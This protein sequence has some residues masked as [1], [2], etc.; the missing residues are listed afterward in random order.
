MRVS[1]H[2][3]DCEYLHYTDNIIS[4]VGNFINV[5]CIVCK[6]EKTLTNPMSYKLHEEIEK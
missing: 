3:N 5:R 4:R 2:C 1:W 6:E